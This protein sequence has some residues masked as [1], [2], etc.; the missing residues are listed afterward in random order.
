M[1]L[2]NNWLASDGIEILLYPITHRNPYS[3]ENLLLAINNLNHLEM[4]LGESSIEYM[5]I[6]QGI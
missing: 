4:P 6:V 3:S 5:S 1:F 2:N